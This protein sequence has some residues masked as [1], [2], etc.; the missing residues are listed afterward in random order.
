MRQEKKLECHS[1]FLTYEPVL[2][3]KYMEVYQCREGAMSN[4]SRE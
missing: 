3:L 2:D 4:P 1:F